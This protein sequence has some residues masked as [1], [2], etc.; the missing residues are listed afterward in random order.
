MK[1]RTALT[2]LEEERA[3]RLAE[4]RHLLALKK[5]N[6]K[7]T[8]SINT[9]ILYEEFYQEL[10]LFFT[11]YDEFL[12]NNLS[13]QEEPSRYPILLDNLDRLLKDRL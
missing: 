1:A 11:N 9:L 12:S 3:D 8:Y 7:Q 6:T 13:N 10:V 5:P 4:L 2:F